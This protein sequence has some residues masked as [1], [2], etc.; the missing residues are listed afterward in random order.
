MTDGAA[1]EDGPAKRGHEAPRCGGTNRKGKP[2]GNAP[3]Y[4]T[5]HPGYANCA[6]H[7]GSTPS[8]ERY[9]ERVAAEQAVA[10]AAARFGVDL[11]GAPPGEIA[12]REIAR[13]SAMVQHLGAMLSEVAADDLIW[14]VAARR[15][16]PSAAP[17]GN[18][19]VVVEQRSRP[20]PLVT[21]LDAERRQLRDWIMAA[22]TAGVEERYVRLAE[23]DGAWAAKIARAMFARFVEAWQPT[24][25]QQAEGQ[26]I[27]A[28]VFRALD[29]GEL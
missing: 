10:A 1:M 8:G 7:G 28:E 2:C 20:H 9:A 24:A 21:M 5:D 23:A 11:D 22:H 12:L 26:A 25:K 16:T 19:Q 29:R 14:G 27:V 3:G 13:S 15:I 6:F 4:K 18:P 17:G